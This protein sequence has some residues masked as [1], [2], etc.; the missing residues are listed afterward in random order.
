[1]RSRLKY[2]KVFSPFT[3]AVSTRLYRTAM[4]FAPLE[5]SI[6][7]KFFRPRVNGRIACS[8][9]L[10]SIGMLPSVEI[11]RITG[12]WFC[13]VD[14]SFLKMKFGVNIHKITKLVMKIHE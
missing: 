2:S 11:R 3:L 6:K 12:L 10:L 9:Q 13:E 14:V 8:A 5:D 4:A 7:T 1:M